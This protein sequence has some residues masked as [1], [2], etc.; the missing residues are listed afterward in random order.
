MGGVD[1]HGIL[2]LVEDDATRSS[3][4]DDLSL[5]V[6]ADVIASIVRTVTV[7]VGNIQIDVGSLV[8]RKFVL[9]GE[10]IHLFADL[11]PSVGGHKLLPLLLH[12]SEL[13]T[14]L[15]FMVLH[16]LPDFFGLLLR[17]AQRLHP[18][19]AVEVVLQHGLELVEADGAVLVVVVLLEFGSR[20]ILRERL[21]NQV[22]VFEVAEHC[23]EQQ[24]EA[25]LVHLLPVGVDLKYELAGFG[26]VLVQGGGRADELVEIDR[27][28]AFEVDV[29]EYLGSLFGS[30]VEFSGDL[31]DA[32]ELV[33]V[34]EEVELVLEVADLVVVEPSEGLQ[35][36]R[37]QY[38]VPHFK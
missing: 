36:R 20:D 5:A 24:V 23:P 6:V 10:R 28:A 12:H 3:V 7:D 37:S 17:E 13:V 31:V 2:I 8:L 26:V 21:L 4:I 11:H 15:N 29:V 32:E 33:L 9:I 22:Q 14:V 35:L 16:L 38:L 19:S 30:G 27:L 18:Q 34:A 1:P 25:V